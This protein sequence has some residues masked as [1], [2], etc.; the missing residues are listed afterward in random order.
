M[1][2]SRFI[3]FRYLRSKSSKNA[4]NYI[5]IIATLGIIV[6]TFALFLVLSV[7]SGLEDY[8]MQFISA[9]DPDIKI[10]PVK[11]K[12]FETNDTLINKIKN[13]EGVTKISGT[14]EERAFF[15]YKKRTHCFYQRR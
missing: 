5:T 2:V 12:Y 15:N 1:N 13:I 6:G 8:S 7:F 14:I 10:T 11:G 4:I 3:A 9:A